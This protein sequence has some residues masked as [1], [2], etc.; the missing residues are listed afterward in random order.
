[1]FTL[2]SLK[3]AERSEAKSAKRSFASNFKNCDSLEAKLR[4][5]QAFYAKFMLTTRGEGKVHFDVSVAFKKWFAFGFTFLT[6]FTFFPFFIFFTFESMTTK[7]SFYPQG[8][9]FSEF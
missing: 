8:L 2:F 4:F 1:L 9:K 3:E 6:F 7:W 5:V